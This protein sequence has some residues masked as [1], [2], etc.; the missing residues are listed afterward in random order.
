M[1]VPWIL[2]DIFSMIILI[3]HGSSA[4]CHFGKSVLPECRS[5]LR[6]SRATWWIKKVFL[7]E[8]AEMEE[9]QEIHQT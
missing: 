8:R 6:S 9:M 2:S 3:P 4:P 5:T 7:Q 1:P